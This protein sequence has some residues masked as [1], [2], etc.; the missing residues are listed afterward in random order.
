MPAIQIE[1]LN[2]QIRTLMDP[3]MPPQSFL[4]S[5]QSFMEAHANLAFRP[6]YEVQQNHPIESYQLA[7]VIKQQLQ[8]H[9]VQFVKTNPNL[10]LQYSELIW[11]QPFIEMK[12]LAATIIGAL[13][14]DYSNSV[15]EKLEFWSIND[16]ETLTRRILFEIGTTSIRKNNVNQWIEIIKNWLESGINTKITAGLLAIQELIIDNQ[17]ENIPAIFN[18]VQP[19]FD[20]QNEPAQNAL[21]GVVKILNNRSPKET[22]YFLRSLLLSEPTQRRNRFVRRCFSFL[23]LNQQQSLRKLMDN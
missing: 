23:P 14:L 16:K 5:L 6:G 20:I 7:P 22:Y 13:P 4:E 12:Q 15:F 8:L 1:R 10:A 9:L 18:M 2:E 19:L 11:N 21:L 3:N 17:F